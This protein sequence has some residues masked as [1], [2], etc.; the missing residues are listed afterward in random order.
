MI[1][2]LL[3][4]IEFKSQEMFM[5]SALFFQILFS[6]NVNNKSENLNTN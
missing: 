5:F 4:L 3:L 1:V 2:F 6:Q